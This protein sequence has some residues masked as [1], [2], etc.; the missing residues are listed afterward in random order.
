MQLFTLQFI[1]KLGL[2]D[3]VFGT[4]NAISSG[5]KDLERCC[6]QCCIYRTKSF[7]SIIIYFRVEGQYRF[8]LYTKQFFVSSSGHAEV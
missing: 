2:N 5:K 1:K 6:I 8:Y 4:T 7:K 3:Y